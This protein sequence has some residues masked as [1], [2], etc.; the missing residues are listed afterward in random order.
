MTA[1]NP[2]WRVIIDGTIYTNYA[3]SNMKIVSGR[4]NIYEQAQAGY[5]DLN[6][7]NLEKTQV[8]IEINDSVTIELQDSTAAF[9]PIFGGTVVDIAITVAETGNVA[10]TQQINIVALGALSRL[11]KALTN[12]V[13]NQDFDGDQIYT[14]LSD[15]LLNNWGEVPAA[16]QW[17][18]YDPTTTWAT[19]ENVGL[20][21]IDQPGDY[22]LANRSS[23]RIDVYSLVSS[24][25]TSG[26]GYIYEDAQGRISYADSTHRID[27]LNT[28]GYVD[29]TATDALGSGISIQS[30]VGDVRNNMTLKYGTNSSFEVSSED[31]D[32]MALYGTLSQ[33]ISTT[34][35]HSSDAQDQADFYISIRAYPAF[36]FQEITFEL[37]NQKISDSDRDAL[38]AVF[39]GM[40]V[41]LSNLPLNMA[42][43]TYLGFVEGWTINT[44]Y[45]RVSV[46][47]IM[48]PLEFSLIAQKW[49]SV[50]PAEAWNTVVNTLQ[51][52]TAT[53]VA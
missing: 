42:A 45:N 15:L 39:M 24:L 20:G 22:E 4:T 48:S 14:I 44:N 53:I 34:I 5:L 10:T 28:N 12:G 25:A 16:L 8:D 17:Q 27:Y 52:Q 50:N 11:Q 2:I 40:P 13:L 26:L 18:N 19:A 43:G 31:L 51:W 23:D 6:L 7:I 21:E 3:L 41:R 30:R 46:S 38:I 9:I 1:W 49:Q 35:K 37:T 36:M 33:I 47:L 29:L 32:S